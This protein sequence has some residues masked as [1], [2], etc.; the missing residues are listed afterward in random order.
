[1]KCRICGS[2]TEFFS[3]A[4][5]L[6]KYNISYF[7]CSLCYSVQTESPFWLNEA[8]SEVI[9][10][11]D[12][13]IVSRT[14]DF[15]RV[16][17]LLIK[18]FFE[19]DSKFVDFGGGYGLFVRMMRDCGYDFYWYDKYCDNLFARDFIAKEGVK[20]N[21]LTA[22]EV[23]EHLVNPLE[24]LETM[25]QF[26]D[27]IFF[28]TFLIPPTF[29]LPEQWWY[30][31][32]EHGQHITLYSKETLKYL[33]GK[34]NLNL[35]TNSKHLHLLTPKKISKIGYRFITFPYIAETFHY[36]ASR[37]TLLDKDYKLVL[38]KIKDNI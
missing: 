26:S 22:F 17:K 34:F 23:F 30:Y 15:V 9:N 24:E 16:S 12:V 6:Q 35:Y 32:T 38:S 31:A 33:A 3:K 4:T 1:M 13:G 7:K 28:S 5:I 37:R 21:L 25:L 11:S 27:S 36:I 19:A 8:Y 2:T 14:L 18:Y 10:R 20:Y 29:P